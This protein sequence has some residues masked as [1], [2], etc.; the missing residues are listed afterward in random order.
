MQSFPQT[1]EDLG[2]GLGKQHQ[3]AFEVRIC[4]VSLRIRALQLL[5]RM[6]FTGAGGRRRR[7]DGLTQQ[8]VQQRI[9][10]CLIRF[11]A[12]GFGFGDHFGGM[13]LSICV[14]GAE[15]FFQSLIFLTRGI[16][17]GLLLCRRALFALLIFL[18]RALIFEQRPRYGFA[19]RIR[20]GG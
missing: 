9:M 8:F 13:R 17:R 20:L 1:D 5:L 14:L 12:Q 18:Q 2:A 19:R 4:G 10:H 15:L 3:H 6:R 11:A 16:E 7:V